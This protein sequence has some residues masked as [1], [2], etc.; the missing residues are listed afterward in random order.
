[1]THHMKKLKRNLLRMLLVLSAI[2]FSLDVSRVQAAITNGLVGHWTFDETN[3]FT[4]ADSSGQG[5][6]GTVINSDSA[7]PEWV[8]GQIG[9]ALT[10]RGETNG[11]D[12]VVVQSY[13]PPTNTFSVSAW[14]FATLQSAWPETGIVENGLTDNSGPIGLVLGVKSESTLNQVGPLED[15]TTDSSSTVTISDPV[16]FP[17]GVWQHVAVVAD[18]SHLR[19]YRN[20]VQVA[21][22]FYNGSLPLASL[23]ALG[24]GAILDSTSFAHG[25]WQGLID[26]VGIWTNA[27]TLGQIVS[28]YNAGNAGKNLTFADQYTNVAP[29][30]TT[31]PASA[32]R[33]AGEGVTFSVGAAGTPPFTFQWKQGGQPIAGATN[34][35]YTIANV[36]AG[37][38]GDQFSVIVSNLT[39]NFPSQPATLTVK[40]TDFSTALAGYWTFDETNGTVAADSTTNDNPVN[41]F[42]YPGDN[43]QWGPGKIGGALYLG[44]F[45]LSEYGAA[46]NYPKPSSTMTI[47]AWVWADTYSP[48]GTFVKNWG[49]TIAGQ[50]HFG[51]LANGGQASIFITEAD[52]TDQNVADSVPMPT[53]SWQQVAFVCDGLFLRLYRNGL[54]VASTS[55]DGTLVA[56][57]MTCAGFGARLDDDCTT[58]AADAG[59]ACVLQ[60]R[61]DDLGIW[62]RGLT[63]AE[64]YGIYAA[65]QAG[66]GLINAGPFLPTAPSIQ[67][68][69]TNVTVFEERTITLTVSASGAS[70]LAFQWLRDGQPIAGA[71]STALALGPATLADNGTYTVLATNSLGSDLSSN[72]IVTVNQRPFATLVSDWKF[73]NNLLDSSTNG[74]DGTAS[75]SVQYVPGK[76][77]MAVQLD[78]GN[79]IVNTMANNLPTN[80][81]DSWSI[82][83]WMNLPSNPPFLAYLA[84]FGPVI[85]NNT[86]GTERGLIALGGNAND[87]YLWG[88]N[89]DVPTTTPYP[90]GTWGMI[91]VTHDGVDSATEMFLN[92]QWIAE[93]V[94]PLV[95]VPSDSDFISLAPTSNW[96]VDVGGEF[97][98]F[99][100]WRGVLPPTQI[101]QL[102]GLGVAL[103]V[104][105]SGTNSIAVSWLAGSAGFTLQ[106]TTNL[107]GASWTNVPNVI[108][109]SIVIPI[110][111]GSQFFRLKD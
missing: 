102:Q 36:T 43:S 27:L 83:L 94:V 92:G 14:V 76:F 32:T 12:F 11:A 44:G 4:A 21:T 59:T 88:A 100:I 50:F 48:Y 103:N 18:G 75:G 30:I 89:A 85:F 53:N 47:S 5:N 35:T 82:N 77:G 39:G 57:A 87:I 108:S 105:L 23:P 90:V 2:L 1:M 37:Q 60:G 61:L 62:S 38:N 45:N 65:G 86:N 52:G 9:G 28:I 97:D 80:A 101:N 29:S 66:Q 81:A 99:T 58:L 79:P 34:A 73:E 40:A 31:Q 24:I 68:Q 17:T 22:D 104:T 42:N 74:N 7:N 72:A 6:D 63:S 51:M 16:A 69:P 13:P 19:L 93:G 78:P 110:G 109:N 8:A 71:T 26:D 46:S 106:S 84:G 10:F 111:Q 107:S 64:I 33:Y 25:Y 67:T 98:E 20:G 56:P 41:L 54:E 70:P 95:D 3:G 49:N 91:T 55:Y 15:I 96:A